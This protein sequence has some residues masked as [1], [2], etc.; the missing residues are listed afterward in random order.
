[1]RIAA[2]F[3]LVLVLLAGTAAAQPAVSTRLA[4]IAG[5]V[6]DENGQPLSSFSVNALP[7]V[8]RNEHV[9]TKRGTVA[10]TSGD[11][12]YIVTNVGPGEYVVVAR[13]LTRVGAE[14]RLDDGRLVHGPT[15]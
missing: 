5:H 8:L 15:F 2:A 7:V 9:V 14:A 10:R 3:V 1:M 4:S 11:G 13:P 6:R 12:T